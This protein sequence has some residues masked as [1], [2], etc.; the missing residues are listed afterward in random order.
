VTEIEQVYARQPEGDD[1]DD[2]LQGWFDVTLPSDA[3]IETL[4]VEPFFEDPDPSAPRMSGKLQE[5]LRRLGGQGGEAEAK[6]TQRFDG[7]SMLGAG[8]P[9]PQGGRS[10]SLPTALNPEALEQKITLRYREFSRQQAPTL[11]RLV[12]PAIMGGGTIEIDIAIQASADQVLGA[13]RSSD[14]RALIEATGEGAA[15]LR[16]R[17]ATRERSLELDAE[18]RSR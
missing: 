18:V 3:I 12:L 11:V 8:K 1:R 17:G 15:R 9:T 4:S 13:V 2:Q 10:Y 14:D 6:T 16:L 7:K 5:G